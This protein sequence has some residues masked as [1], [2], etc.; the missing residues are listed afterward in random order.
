MKITCIGSGVFSYAI[1][2]LLKEKGNTL[3][4]WSHKKEE[5]TKENWATFQNE[6]IFYTTDLKE[7]CSFSDEI[8]LLISSPFME[9]I[10][11]KIKEFDIHKKTLYIG[12]K[13]L[14]SHEPYFYSS[15]CEKSDI[16]C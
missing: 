3:M 4:I 7:A 6:H 2:T 5:F 14:L 16:K 12:T 11:T 15:Y 8:F 9:D 13:G 10:L 1:A